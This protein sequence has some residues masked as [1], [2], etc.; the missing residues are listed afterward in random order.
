MQ[1][2]EPPLRGNIPVTVLLMSKGAEVS[3]S[4]S[5]YI[6]NESMKLFPLGII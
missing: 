6:W 1:N 3:L 5:I 4:H 2:Q